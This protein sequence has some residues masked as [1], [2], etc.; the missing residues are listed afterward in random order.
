MCAPAGSGR[1]LRGAGLLGLAG[2]PVSVVDHLAF[3]LVVLWRIIEEPFAICAMF[4]ECAFRGC[5]AVCAA[6]VVAFGG[7]VLGD[8]GMVVGAVVVGTDCAV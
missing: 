8:V 5:R 6:A 3:G 4:E 7:G 2:A 1:H